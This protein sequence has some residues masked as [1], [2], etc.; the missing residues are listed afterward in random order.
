MA[1]TSISPLDGRYAT[2]VQSL[3]PYVSEEAL[4]HYRVRVLSSAV[5]VQTVCPRAPRGCRPCGRGRPAGRREKWL[6]E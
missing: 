2:Q 1:L 6:V 4:I 3:A 5:P